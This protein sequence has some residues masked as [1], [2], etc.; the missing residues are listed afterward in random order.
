M[1]HPQRAA[2][3]DVGLQQALVHQGK[4]RIVLPGLGFQ[5]TTRPRPGRPRT[6]DAGPIEW[7]RFDSIAQA[8]SRTG[9]PVAMFR[10]A[11]KEGCPGFRDS[12]VYFGEFLKWWGQRGGEEASEDWGKAL[13]REQTLRT[14]Q[15][16]EKEAGRLL[17]ADLVSDGITR[18]LSRVFGEMERCFVEKFPATAKGRTEVEIRD[19]SVKAIEEMKSALREALTAP[20]AFG[21][22]EQEKE[23]S[24]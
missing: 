4:P 15:L 11:K 22:Q 6:V 14:R 3:A 9:L 12:R 2:G 7:P 10:L 19:A 21:E 5:M 16:R 23:S 17:A 24:E 1:G 18:G 20:G 8:S 13:K